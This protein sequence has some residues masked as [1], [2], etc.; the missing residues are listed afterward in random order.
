MR[1][2]ATTRRIF[3]FT[4]VLL[5]IEFLDEF[6][7]GVREA[8]WPLIRDDLGLSYI[9]IGIL[10]SM[11]NL[12]ASFIEPGLGILGDVWKRKLL[13]LGGGMIFTMS[14]L[15]TA[16][17]GSFIPLLVSFILF[18]PASGAFVGLSQATL[19]DANPQRHQQNMAR[20]T[21]A[22]S[23]GIVIGTIAIGALSIIGIGWRE[24]FLFAAI[25]SFSLVIW[26][27]R[28]Q[29]AQS[30]ASDDG[31]NITFRTGIKNAINALRRREVQRWLVLLEFSDLML[32]ILH[33]YLA[34]YFVDVVRV[35]PAHAGFAVAVWTGVG[36][37]GDFL[38][39]PLLER[40]HGLDY[41]R[42]SAGLELVLFPAFLLVPG[43]IPKLLILAFIGFFNAGWYSILKGQL[44]S[45][46]P[47]Q[48]GMVMAVNNISGLLG[49]LLPFA[50]GMAAE[51][52]GL[53]VAIWLVML[54]PVALL[55]G[56][57]H[58]KTEDIQDN[59]QLE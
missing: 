41:L 44:Y 32:D 50:I 45:S 16:I 57:P 51:Q 37:I 9:E 48:S 56:I 47:G 8:A 40:V 38:L 4:F 59:R 55:I 10:L 7:F 2:T 39:I 36:L 22:G 52:F 58:R 54:G 24:L 31:E 6:I 3:T 14:L 19:M 5:A 12:I 30:A 18:N 13:V 26:A 29:F 11:P 34:L 43:I 35:E 42:I 1:R 46:M 20:W 25:V 33:G 53:D 23:L 27:S 21:F 17:S 28:Y 49:S 15:L